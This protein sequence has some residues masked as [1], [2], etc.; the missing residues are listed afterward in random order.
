MPKFDQ[1]FIGNVLAGLALAFLIDNLAMGGV[2]TKTLPAE[3][4][5]I[6]GFIIFAGVC[7][8]GFKQA[9]KLN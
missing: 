9:K 2:V 7:L 6:I 3:I 8:Y 1:V 4:V 5:G